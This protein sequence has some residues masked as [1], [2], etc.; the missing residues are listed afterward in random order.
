MSDQFPQDDAPV[1]AKPEVFKNGSRSKL[2]L[3]KGYSRY[4]AQMG[5]RDELPSDPEVPVLLHLE[6]LRFEDGDY[7]QGGAYWGYTPGTLIYC[8]WTN[9]PERVRIWHRAAG[10]EAAKAHVQALVPGAMFF[11]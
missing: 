3:E 10:R 7:D 11:R 8:A 4:G 6:A 1:A 2:T 9:E 5:R